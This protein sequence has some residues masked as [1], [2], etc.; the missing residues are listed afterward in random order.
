[1]ILCTFVV[2]FLD[3]INFVLNNNIAFIYIVDGDDFGETL[4]WTVLLGNSSP[5]ALHL[6]RL[7]K[8]ITL[9]IAIALGNNAAGNVANAIHAL[10][11][12]TVSLAQ[13]DIDSL[14]QTF[15]PL[16]IAMKKALDSLKKN[17]SHPESPQKKLQS[18]WETVRRRLAEFLREGTGSWPN[19]EAIV[20][21]LA[22]GLKTAFHLACRGFAPPDIHMRPISLQAHTKLTPLYKFLRVRA[23]GS[24]TLGSYPF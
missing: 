8:N 9:V 7:S 10:L 18:Q 1:M 19:L 3:I 2:L 14:K 20:S 22:V 24:F 13:R 6:H 11:A 5:H 16:D 17:K 12:A 15:N 23:I 4:S 21:S